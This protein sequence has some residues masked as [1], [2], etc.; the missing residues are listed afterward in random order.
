M[1]PLVECVCSDE[2][3]G[4]VAGRIYVRLD[5]EYDDDERNEELY[6]VQDPHTGEV[7]EAD[8]NFFDEV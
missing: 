8:K 7:F 5:N 1:I 4:I 2:H 6:T 3:I